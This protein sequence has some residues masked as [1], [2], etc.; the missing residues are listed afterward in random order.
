MRRKNRSK[1]LNYMEIYKNYND[2]R[3][4]CAAKKHFTKTEHHENFFNF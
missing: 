3:V 2:F 4:W 1:D